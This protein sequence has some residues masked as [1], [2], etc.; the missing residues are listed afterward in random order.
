MKN[1]KRKTSKM[2]IFNAGV[3]MLCLSCSIRAFAE[4]NILFG[5]LDMVMAIANGVISVRGYIY[6]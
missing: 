5:I 1:K 2:W 3:C 6:R 4:N